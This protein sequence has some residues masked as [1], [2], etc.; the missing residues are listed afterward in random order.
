MKKAILF[1][2][3]F[4]VTGCIEWIT[5]DYSI[6]V[7]NADA[8][9]M[10]DKPDLMASGIIIPQDGNLCT[11]AGKIV[12]C[13][14]NYFWVTV[15]ANGKTAY[16]PVAYQSLITGQSG[17]EFCIYEKVLPDQRIPTIDEVKET[18][19]ELQPYS[20]Q[21][22]E[23][24]QEPPEQIPIPQETAE[25]TAM[26]QPV[27]VA[28]SGGAISCSTL[29]PQAKNLLIKMVFREAARKGIYSD[30]VVD[31]EIRGITIVI[32]NRAISDYWS[33]SADLSESIEAVISAPAQFTPYSYY[34]GWF[35][36]NNWATPLGNYEWIDADTARSYEEE[37]CEAVDSYAT[38]RDSE[39][40]PV[41]NQHYC[42]FGAGGAEPCVNLDVH[43]QTN[44]YPTNFKICGYECKL[45]KAGYF[46][47]AP[48]PVK[49]T[50][51]TPQENQEP[52]VTESPKIGGSC[53]GYGDSGVCATPEQ[54]PI[55]NSA[56]YDE[57]SQTYTYPLCGGDL[58]LQEQSYSDQCPEGSVCCISVPALPDTVVDIDGNPRRSCMTTY[59][60]E[61]WV[62]GKGRYVIGYC[63]RD[64]EC[65]ECG[66]FLM[67]KCTIT[68]GKGTSLS[69]VR[70]EG[71]YITTEESRRC[72][73]YEEGCCIT[74]TT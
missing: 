71:E 48:P 40:P 5:S 44:T 62:P 51:E 32:L 9:F 47:Q 13:E 26:P 11:S 23:V 60:S 28:P 14:E 6:C 69:M 52:A 18:C 70:W 7:V 17:P 12:R 37:V 16:C 65:S 38:I 3:L 19:S 4:L 72:I 41:G 73:K 27:S 63:A 20:P 56:K 68:Y 36:E 35:S 24:P 15:A 31:Y 25:P 1:I 45:E 46:T 55:C 54:C 49:P 43:G 22:F 74:K 10:R 64:N 58:F 29:T 61:E 50:Q 66:G 34:P 30:S 2:I 59:A 53:V 21:Q 67:P 57:S 39:F 42:F 8:V 33:A